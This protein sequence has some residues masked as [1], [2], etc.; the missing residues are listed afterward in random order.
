MMGHIS[1]AYAAQVAQDLSLCSR[2][3][4]NIYSYESQ[5]TFGS[6]W[7]I[8]KETRD[9]LSPPE[10]IPDAPNEILSRHS[11]ETQ[12]VVKAR[13]STKMVIHCFS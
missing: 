6:E 12:G 13:M 5:W 11:Q 1:T 9:I 8:Q 3:D 7:W 4:F 2:F 10:E